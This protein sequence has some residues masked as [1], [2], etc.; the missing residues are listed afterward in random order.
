MKQWYKSEIQKHQVMDKQLNQYIEFSTWCLHFRRHRN[1]LVTEHFL[2]SLVEKYGR[3]MVYSDG[4]SWYP[5]PG[6]SLRLA[7]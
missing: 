4:G 5:K 2:Y 6:F 7:K 1:M 3:H